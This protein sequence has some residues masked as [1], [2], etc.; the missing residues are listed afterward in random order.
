VSAKKKATRKM[1]KPT[2]ARTSARP[3]PRRSKAAGPDPERGGRVVTFYSYKG[4]TGRTMALAN[5]AW[6]LAA[7]GRQVLMIDWDL[8]A[9][10]LHRY[11]GPFLEDPELSRSPGLIDF[12]A[13]FAEGARV[14]ALKQTAARP[15]A[16]PDWYQQYS[17]LLRFAVPVDHEFSSGGS[18]DLI[19]AGRQGPSYGLLVNSMHWDDFYDKLGGGVFLETVKAQLRKEYHYILIDSRTGLSDTAGICTVQMPDE[20]VVCFTLNRQSIAGAAAI[21]DS[22]GR[23]R[24]KPSGEPGLKIWPI[25]MR[26]ELAEKERLEAARS[27]TRDQFA[28]SLWHLKRTQRA[29]YWEGIEVLYFPYYAYEEVLATVADRPRTSATLLNA[30]EVI[31]GHLTGGA[32]SQ[33]AAI[34]ETDRLALL[35]RYVETARTRSGSD[36]TADHRIYLSYAHKDIPPQ[37]MRG[38][39]EHLQQSL[40]PCHIAW[41]DTV[42]LG[43]DWAAYMEGEMDR[44]DI[45]VVFLSPAGLK[46]KSVTQETSAAVDKK[47]VLV[48]V[49]IGTDAPRYW[50]S[51]PPDIKSLRGVSLP[52]PAEWTPETLRPLA[53]GLKRLLVNLPRRSPVD[54]DD[55]QKGQW[56]GKNRHNG[57]ELTATVV[58][59]SKNWFEIIL[60]VRTV[61][62]KPLTGPVTFHLHQSFENETETVEAD[63]GEATL[64]LHAYGAFT[65]GA[66]MDDGRTTLELDL[67]ELKGAPKEFREA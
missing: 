38:L 66:V 1:P 63:D 60:T 62:S 15:S 39:V 54:P 22:A 56:G 17:D 21:A 41:D 28:S 30:M 3:A 48:P 49:F 13:E 65:V 36:G 9:P 57:R 14:E 51:V 18:I 16:A 10:G 24:R 20:L 61:R 2:R 40:P 42:P 58:R 5:V 33:F 46:S 7:A 29:Q 59:V 67:A 43:T 27:T 31:T 37:Q 4:G 26:V 55:P 44:A 25:P 8:E 23:A 47:K 6:I 35:A 34:T 32:V 52:R 53:D 50:S 45:V 64:T 11:F 19:P 12:F